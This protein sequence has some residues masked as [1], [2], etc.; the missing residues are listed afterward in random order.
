M[1]GKEVKYIYLIFLAM[2]LL[3]SPSL[4]ALTLDEAVKTALENNHRSEEHTSEL[5]SH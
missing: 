1:T 5:Q 4:Y 2:L 3:L